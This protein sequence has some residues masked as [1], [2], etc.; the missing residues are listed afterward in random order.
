MYV[1]GRTAAAS[2]LGQE[3]SLENRLSS[4]HFSH[5]SKVEQIESELQKLSRAELRQIRDWLNDFVEDTL[6]FTP[7]FES[8]IRESEKEMSSGIQPRVRKP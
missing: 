4:G 5:M 1:D 2:V 8:A 6:E 3:D 7:E